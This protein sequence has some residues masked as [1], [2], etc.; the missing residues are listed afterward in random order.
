[1]IFNGCHAIFLT[2]Y[3]RSC[4]FSMRMIGECLVLSV[5]VAAG[6]QATLPL[7]S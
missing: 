1:M 3:A 6:I 7:L 5:S 2:G 4:S